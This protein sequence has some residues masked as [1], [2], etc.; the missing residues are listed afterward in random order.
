MEL[1]SDG[2]ILTAT[3]QI[4]LKRERE[5]EKERNFQHIILLMYRQ[6]ERIAQAM[7]QAM[8]VFADLA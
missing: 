5:R 4:K 3:T 2:V 8:N 7:N 6:D 1:N